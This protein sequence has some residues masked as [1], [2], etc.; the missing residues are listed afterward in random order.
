MLRTAWLAIIAGAL[1]LQ[2]ADAEIYTWVD[3]SGSVNV[4][5]LAP[6]KDVRVIKV[7]P[8]LAPATA[9]RNEAAR[10]AARL[11]E[12][13]ALEERVRQLEGEVEAAK[14]Q[15]PPVVY[16]EMPAPPPPRYRAPP[17]RYAVVSTPP[18][19]SGCDAG[20]MDC[21]LG[22]GWSPAF[23]PTSVIVLR[24]PGFRRFPAVRTGRHFTV[25]QPGRPSHG[26][27]RG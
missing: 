11:A 16:S 12:T 26:F 7:T 6:P 17:V 14:R 5:N 9:A 18:A 22:L 4:G 24:A 20:W 2:A 25:R 3:T 21:G 23:F 13:Q 27:R 15:P 19:Y 1:G 8:A 10:E